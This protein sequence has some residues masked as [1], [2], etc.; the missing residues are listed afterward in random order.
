MARKRSRRTARSSRRRSRLDKRVEQFS[1]EVEA[2]GKRFGRKGGE[3][4][5]WF[6]RT[7]GLV[8]P[9]ISSIFGLLIIS[10]IIWLLNFMSLKAGVLMFSGIAAFLTLN[11][12]WFFLIFLFFSYTSYLSWCCPRTYLLFSPIL[13]GLGIIIALWVFARVLAITNLYLGIPVISTMVFYLEMLLMPIFW[14]IVFIGYIIVFVKLLYEKPAARVAAQRTI[15][16]S[17][18]SSRRASGRGGKVN[19][20]YR[21]GRDRIL[22]GVCGGIAEYLGVDP[23]IIR[24]LWVIA[25]FA[26]GFGVL[27]YIIAWIIIPRNPRHRW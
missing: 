22:G 27:A 23:V 1:E 19:R 8:G 26:W 3:W 15:R 20:L 18:R 11:I 24:L 10:L 21:S 9:V 25:I 4:G 6:H 17:L 12:G 7:F 2:F 13:K 5:T 16:S 14:L